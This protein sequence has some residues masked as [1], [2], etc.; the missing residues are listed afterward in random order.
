MI[1]SAGFDATA[2]IWGTYDIGKPRTRILI[3]AINKCFADVYKCHKDIW[4]GVEDK[5]QIKSSFRK[6]TIIIRWLFAYPILVLRYC[7]LPKHEFLFIPYMGIVDVLIIYPFAKMRGA[8]ICMDIFISVYDT[9]VIDR[10]LL[11][12]SSWLARLVY[13][14]EKRAIQLADKCFIDTQTHADYIEGLFNL[15]KGEIDILYVGVE[16]D[17]FPRLKQKVELKKKNSP[18]TVLFYGQFIPL[19]GIDIVVGAAEIVEKHHGDRLIWK[20]IGSGQTE[21]DIDDQIAENALQSISRVNWVNYDSL[22][23]E[24]QN[25]DICLGVF[26]REGKSQRVIP[27]KVY[28]I[29]AVGSPLITADSPAIREKIKPDECISLV[30]PGDPRAL[31]KAVLEMAERL[32]RYTLDCSAMP[33]I[34]ADFVSDQLANVLQDKVTAVCQGD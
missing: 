15:K 25:A 30:Q 4:R 27:N 18:L 21:A 22:A 32:S 8:T 2:V 17:K 5:T 11:D 24:I 14:I 20:I 29:L 13:V 26:S 33:R 1:D 6:L 10:G 31:A 34:T 16:E 7:R 28:Q 9:I 12:K 19:H 23:T 3:T